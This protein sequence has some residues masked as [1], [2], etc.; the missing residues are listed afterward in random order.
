MFFGTFLC[1]VPFQALAQDDILDAIEAELKAEEEKKK[2]AAKAS[3]NE[4][5]Y[6]ANYEASIRKGDAYIRS[7]KYD[8]ALEAFEEAKKWGP[9]ESYPD[10]QIAL[11]RQEKT[12]QEA[13][14]KQ[15]KI[16]A[17]YN[18]A[19]KIADDLF[20]SKKYNSSI[21]EYQ[22]AKQIDQ[23]MAYPTDQIAEAKKLQAKLEEERKKA[24]ATKKL[25][26]DY[27]AALDNGDELLKK[28][29]FDNAIVAYQ[30]AATLKPSEPAPKSKIQTAKKSKADAEAKAAAEK[31]DKEFTAAMEKADGLLA[32]GKYD[33]SISAYKE[34]QKIKPADPSPKTKITEAEAKKK[35]AADAATKAKYD[36]LID[37]AD[38][39]LKNSQFDEAK[40][41]YN[42]AAA[43][44]PNETYPK[45]KAKECGE[46][47]VAAGKAELKAQYDA[48]VKEADGLL[49]KEE[50]DAAKKKY[51]EALAVL[52]H[53]THPAT[54]IT[55]AESRK[56][57]KATAII[58]A[59]YDEVINAA[60]QMVKEEK[61]DEAVIKYQ[62]AKKILPNENH[63]DDMLLE[64]EKLKKQK[65]NEASQT[66]FEAQLAIGEGLMKEE[67]FDEA[68]AA[69][70]AAHKILPTENKTT[71]LIAESKKLKE[72]RKQNALQADFDSKVKEGESLL[73]EE[74]FD[75]AIAKFN[76]AAAILPANQK[77]KFLIEEVQK[78]R[79]EKEA[80]EALIKFNGLVAEGDAAMSSEDFVTARIKFNEASTIYKEGK[81]TIDKK[82]AE[83]GQK[84]N[85][86][87]NAE[88]AAA[89]EAEKQ[90]KFDELVAS[91]N[92]KT[93]TGDYSDAMTALNQAL[94]LYPE[95]QEAIALKTEL[96]GRIKDEKANAE[97][98][99]A[100]DK[101][102]K[103][104][105]IEA[106][107][108]KLVAE[109]EAARV[110]AEKA[111]AK[112]ASKE[113]VARA[114][115]D[116]FAAEQ[117]ATKDAEDKLKT[118]RTASKKADIEAATKAQA[119]EAR[120]KQVKEDAAAKAEIDNV[121][122]EQKAATGVADSSNSDKPDTGV[123]VKENMR[124]VRL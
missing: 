113:A 5:K 17:E 31:I 123:S 58:K 116:K 107:K 62:E 106:D 12:K 40:V 44:L 103:E 19:I 100:A 1:S 118:D 80:A 25:E 120:A 18:A 97:K 104:A 34:A 21:P 98:A 102:A 49:E 67:K 23:T 2:A 50:F 64:I 38:N 90:K 33:E 14:E 72:E 122:P 47:K 56:K 8:D 51:Q 41:K 79:A 73:N 74:Q 89:K 43:V 32:A 111:K 77:P 121:A 24:E 36:A 48:L 35:Q 13:A 95:N 94:S 93:G 30:K 60:D 119:T 85:E 61:F 124:P 109:A 42:A 86:K 10:Q 92:E 66:Q 108:K 112:Q 57:A 81:N 4:A 99:A 39:L 20:N 69:F 29:D 82:L 46:L 68:I 70:E 83:L 117:Q 11:A 63:P 26:A 9:L 27:Q 54:M 105:A 28:N 22:K 15:A 52:P 16:E 45:T 84:E 76:E 6:K 87:Q 91:A 114:Q 3:K 7:K 53:E 59:Q 55:E 96:D 71:E 115:A 37:E 101:L 88:M 65:A 78:K 110:A 75:Q